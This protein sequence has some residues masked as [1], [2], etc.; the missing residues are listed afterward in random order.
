MAVYAFRSVVLKFLSRHVDLLQCCKIE[1]V[2]AAILFLF[3][4]GTVILVVEP[5]YFQL[6]N[7]TCEG[8]FFTLLVSVLATNL[9]SALFL[10]AGIVTL[11]IA[12][13]IGCVLL[14]MF[15]GFS[16]KVAVGTFG[17]GHVIVQTW[18]YTP[19]EVYGFILAGASGL[20]VA[21]R[22][23]ILG[24]SPCQAYQNARSTA[25]SLLAYSVII[26]VI[27]AV[28]EATVAVFNI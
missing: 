13:G 11:G 20:V 12:A 2:T 17:V 16:V 5:Q 18:I 22:I 4:A 10:F 19:F 9:P 7:M 14:G 15:L 27:S 21:R 3:P 23:L 6:G 25:L 24:E 1:V 26:L 8:N 28:I